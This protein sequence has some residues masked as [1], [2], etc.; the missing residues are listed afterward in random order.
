[1]IQCMP[2]TGALSTEQGPWRSSHAA[3]SAGDSPEEAAP[4]E[5]MSE[6]HGCPHGGAVV[7]GGQ[8]PHGGVLPCRL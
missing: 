2:R 3:S 6:G 5:S 7:F 1:M 4:P 8:V